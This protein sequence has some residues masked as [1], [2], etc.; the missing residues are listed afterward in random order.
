M[1][2]SVVAI[3]TG[4]NVRP[5]SQ[6]ELAGKRSQKGRIRKMKCVKA[7]INRMNGEREEE[8]IEGAVSKIKGLT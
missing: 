5:W 3:S 7:W 1:R 6:C 8:E 4:L 2:I